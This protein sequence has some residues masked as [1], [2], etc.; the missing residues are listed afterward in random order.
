MVSSLITIIDVSSLSTTR[1]TCR[2]PQKRTWRPS[3]MRWEPAGTCI[4]LSLSFQD[5]IAHSRPLRPEWNWSTPKSRRLYR[6]WFC[7]PF[8]TGLSRKPALQWERTCK[9]WYSQRLVAWK[10]QPVRVWHSSPMKSSKSNI[11]IPVAI[12][13]F[14]EAFWLRH[15]SQRHYL[16]PLTN[17]RCSLNTMSSLS[18]FYN[19]LSIRHIWD[20][21]FCEIGRQ[22]AFE[23]SLRL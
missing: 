23:L 4:S 10:S 17:W 5:W 18:L 22:E 15:I 12:I 6:L 13:I 3:L 14:F 8:P 16:Q 2:F 20:A 11:K 1:R 9:I 19:I 21:Y 7:K